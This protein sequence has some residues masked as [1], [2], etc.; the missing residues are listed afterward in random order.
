[1]NTCFD[2]HFPDDAWEEYAMGMLSEEN[3]TALE[4]HLL[5]CS[6]CQDRLAE[7]D[8]YTQIVRAAVAL[9]ERKPNAEPLVGHSAK[10]A[11]R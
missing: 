10:V 11:F 2:R 5:I 8:K 4:E 3:C 7:L 6:R 1:M 9:Q